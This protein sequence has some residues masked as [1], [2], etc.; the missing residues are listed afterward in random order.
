MDYMMSSSLN[1]SRDFFSA[2]EDEILTSINVADEIIESFYPYQ[3]SIPFTSGSNIVDL[4]NSDRSN[5][6]VGQYLTSSNLPP[7]T[8]ITDFYT[9]QDSQY[10]E[11]FGMVYDDPEYYM[12]LN[13][14]S[15]TAGEYNVTL[16][17]REPRYTFDGVVQLSMKH[18][19]V[20]EGF[21]TSYAG[22]TCEAG[23]QWIL[24]AGYYKTPEITINE[25]DILVDGGLLIQTHA[26]KSDTFN[27]AK[28]TFVSPADFYAATEAPAITSSFY[29]EKDQGEEIWQTIELPYCTSPIQAQRHAKIALFDNRLDMMIQMTLNYGAVRCRV[30]DN[31]LVN[32]SRYGWVEKPFKVLQMVIDYSKMQVKM[33]CKETS[34]LVYDWSATDEQVFTSVPRS[35]LPDPRFVSTPINISIAAGTDQLK[36]LQDGTIIPQAT[37]NWEL[38]GSVNLVEIYGKALTASVWQ[39]V[40]S[41]PSDQTTYTTQ[42]VE[43]DVSWSFGFYAVNSFGVRS[44]FFTQSAYILGKTEA[45]SEPTGLYAYPGAGIVSLNWNNPADLDYYQTNV[46]ASTSSVFNES[47]LYASTPANSIVFNAGTSLAMHHF[48]I[49]GEDTTGNTSS[50]VGSVSGAANPASIVSPDVFINIP[51]NADGVVSNWATSRFTAS[52]SVNNEQISYYAFPDILQNTFRLGTFVSQSCTRDTS[53]LGA[54]IGINAM[55]EDTAMMTYQIIYRASSGIDY[56]ITTNVRYAKARAGATGSAG[57]PGVSAITTQFDEGFMFGDYQGNVSQSDIPFSTIKV[58]V[59][60]TEAAFIGYSGPINNSEYWIDADNISVVGTGYNGW[61]NNL[62]DLNVLRPT[63]TTNPGTPESPGYMIVPIWVRNELGTEIYKEITIP[64]YIVMEG[65]PGIDGASGSNAGPSYG[66]QSDTTA[67][68]LRLIDS[69]SVIQSG[70]GFKTYGSN[71]TGIWIG[72]TEAGA[73]TFDVGSSASYIRFNESESK[74]AIK[75]DEFRHHNNLY[76][77]SSLDGGV[78]SSLMKFAGQQNEIN[79]AAYSH[80]SI[81]YSY[82]ESKNNLTDAKVRL[83]ESRV[84]FSG[85]ANNEIIRINRGNVDGQL[86][87]TSASAGDVTLIAT[88]SYAISYV[89]H[90]ITS[91]ITYA[92]NSLS[93]SYAETASTAVSAAYALSASHAEEADWAEYAGNAGLATMATEAVSASY[94]EFALTASYVMNGGGG[95]SISCSWASSSISSS[96]AVTASYA[97]NAGQ[98]YQDVSFKRAVFNP[99]YSSGN[100]NVEMY[101]WDVGAATQNKLWMRTNGG[102]AYTSLAT[103][104]ATLAMQDVSSTSSIALTA[105][106]VSVTGSF[107]AQSMTGSLLGTASYAITASYALNGGGGSSISCSWASQSISSSYAEIANSIVETIVRPITASGDVFVVTAPFNASGSTAQTFVRSRT[108]VGNTEYAFNQIIVNSRIDDTSSYDPNSDSSIT[109]QSY[110]RDVGESTITI[111]PSLI[112]L[113]GDVQVTGTLEATASYAITSSYVSYPTT[114][115]T[116]TGSATLTNSPVSGNPTGWIDITIAGVVRKMPYW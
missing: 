81:G 51:A 18:K 83:V 11:D 61:E 59:G 112:R 42:Q 33:T 49:R 23:G 54:N 92:T 57:N 110:Y 87:F 53:L 88:A 107:G 44:D 22:M 55:T 65:P 21:I 15:T 102:N 82:V 29:K 90:T 64:W 74:V 96:Y 111:T 94:S 104:N 58:F 19:N 115:S 108:M 10:D 50:L 1:I 84:E 76:I 2:Y 25:E 34:P 72:M 4:T 9:V 75:A 73:V 116:G 27:C 48:W 14:L 43:Q 8:W 37:I 52:L 36:M 91:S 97:L 3:T 103:K 47:F 80:P 68:V 46:Y 71:N 40:V 35:F 28:P 105:N 67:G 41:I 7:D 20:L 31:I 85:D 38:T 39:P 63:L 78:T 26:D 79:I 69:G 12:V 77:T 70:S 66:L 60:A 101:A 109:L 114:G 6:Y 13:N 89:T 106:N 95:S 5:L 93:A 62:V 24:Q 100:P 17:E 98:I 56:P 86:L 16:S 30:G 45:P 99:Y 113:L 32:H